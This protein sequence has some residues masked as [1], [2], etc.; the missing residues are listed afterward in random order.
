[1]LDER[2]TGAVL[3][4]FAVLLFWRLLVV[5][6]TAKVLGSRYE[7]FHETSKVIR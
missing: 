5:L 1:M 7:Y 2:D 3:E 4:D 6:L